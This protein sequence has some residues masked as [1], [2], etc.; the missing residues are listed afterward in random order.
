MVTVLTLL[1]AWIFWPKIPKFDDVDEQLSGTW[2][3]VGRAVEKNPK[4]IWISTAL[5]LTILAGFSFTLKA[6]GLANTE[7]FTARTD[8]VIGLEELGKHFPGGEGSPVEVVIKENDIAAVTNVLGAIANVAFVEPVVAGQKIP[9]A[10]TPP[11]KV[12]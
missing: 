8:S 12:K 11:V 5:L 1:P 9:G 6:D 7:A 4:R 10:P 2:S 3:K